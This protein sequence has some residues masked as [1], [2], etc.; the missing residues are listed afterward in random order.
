MT[1]GDLAFLAG[2]E[3]AAM[4]EPEREVNGAYAGDL[5]SWVM[6]RAGAD[7]AWITIMSNINV[8]AVSVLADVSCVILAEGVKPD[9]DMLA[10]AK[11]K[12]I[13]ILLSDKPTYETAKIL[14][15]LGI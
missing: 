15:G 14:C 4:P 9:A 12:G 6:G 13:N 7:C 1:V 2:L 10:A 11:Q 8:S 5:L 3:S